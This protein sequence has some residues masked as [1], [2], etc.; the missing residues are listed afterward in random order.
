[1]AD[2]DF[3]LLIA[4]RTDKLDARSTAGCRKLLIGSNRDVDEADGSNK[5]YLALCAVDLKSE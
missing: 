3:I 1:M 4:P 2:I 5:E